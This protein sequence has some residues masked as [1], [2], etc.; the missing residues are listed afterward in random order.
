[1]IEPENK[2]SKGGKARAAKL[3]DQARSDIARRAA[4]VRWERAGKLDGLPEVLCGA[5]DHPLCIGSVEVPCYVLNDERRV[6]AQRGV[7]TALGMSSGTG[8][9]GEGDRLSKFM[10]T[11][12]ISPY[13]TES[14][15][16][17]LTDPI[18]FRLGGGALAY[19][20]EATV[21]ADI[22]EAVLQARK[23]GQL[24]AQQVHIADQCEILVRSFAKVGI[25]ALVDE[26]T[27]FQYIR[28]RDALTE[29]LS[30]F[31]SEELRR[32]AKTFPDA[33]FRELCRLRGVHFRPDLRLP[34]YFGYLTRDVVYR[35]LAP[36]VLKE[37]EERNPK[38]VGGKRS[39]KHHQW[40]SED[41][42]HPRLIQHLGTVIGLMKIS[43]TWDT[44]ISHL[45]KVAPIYQDLPLFRGLQA[46]ESQQ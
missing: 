32:W 46:N 43:D 7:I 24:H 27:G 42:G 18:K 15:R 2:Q 4:A 35:R 44:F 25:I 40:L 41:V 28:Q 20:Y 22:C 38:G 36:N 37:L 34:R 39:A 13:V 17:V 11:K 21:L 45:D 29:L 1:M 30:E 33:Y 3:G 26:A 19:G 9:S 5:A 6:L 14:L 23:D 12:G 31:L 8:G 10:E 16:A